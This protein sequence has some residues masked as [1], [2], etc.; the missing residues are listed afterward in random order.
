M[1][2]RVYIG[3]FLINNLG[4]D[5]FLKVLLEKY[6]SYSFFVDL[7]EE[8]RTP[9][10]KYNN[11]SFVKHYPC[12]DFLNRITY[13]L[14]HFR[15]FE[16]VR[17]KSALSVIDI[18]GSL[19]IEQP[20]WKKAFDC[21]IK[22]LNKNNIFIG[23]N[24]GPYTDKNFVEIYRRFFE[25]CRFISWRD[26]YSYDIF[27]MNNMQFAPDFVFNLSIKQ[28]FQ[29]E[30]GRV[31]IIPADVR[32]VV[33]LSYSHEAYIKKMVE[34]TQKCVEKGFIVEL[35]AF[36][37]AFHDDDVCY[38]ICKQLNEAQKRCVDIYVYKNDMNEAIE[39]IQRS[40][41][42]VPTRFHGMILGW[43]CEKRVYPIVYTKKQT[44]EMEMLRYNGGYTRIEDIL[45]LD[46][47]LV[48]SQ[49][50]KLNGLEITCEEA[51]RHFGAIDRILYEG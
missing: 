26:K 22:Q 21:R 14:F 44:D 3:A 6:P 32:N 37:K 24:F 2:Q 4:D 41:Y 8:Y 39:H 23:C 50:S 48:L 16:L 46:T 34:L 7:E 27:S 25:K 35:M 13:K 29:T 47:D 9:F 30:D 11:I 10:L 12:E 20:G 1:K 49:A 42:I 51:Q 5:L 31:L 19:F 45:S 18:G 38:E 43:L 33:G 36:C 40:E 28:S 15:V 17:R